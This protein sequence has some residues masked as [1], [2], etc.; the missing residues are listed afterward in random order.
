MYLYPWKRCLKFTLAGSLFEKISTWSCRF[1]RRITLKNFLGIK[2][3]ALQNGNHKENCKLLIIAY[4]YHSLT[5]LHF[6]VQ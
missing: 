5:L 2:M 6:S 4:S 1:F 3:I